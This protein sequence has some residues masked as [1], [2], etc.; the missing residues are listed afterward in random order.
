MSIDHTIEILNITPKQI[1]CK[2]IQY[3]TI[4]A[5]KGNNIT[6]IITK[7]EIKS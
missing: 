5:K 2:L 6:M 7:I 1:K 4:N 3:S